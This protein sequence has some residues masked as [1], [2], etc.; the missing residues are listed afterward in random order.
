MDKEIDLSRKLNHSV[1]SVNSQI[2]AKLSSKAASTKQEISQ[3][4]QMERSESSQ[5]PA[6]SRK[7]SL[8]NL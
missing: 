3:A 2:L 7:H 4:E 6:V 8:P 5:H 1:G